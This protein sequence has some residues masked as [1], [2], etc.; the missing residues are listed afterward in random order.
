M[1]LGRDILKA[2]WLNIQWYDHVIEAYDGTL[3]GSMA[4]IVDMGT[5]GFKI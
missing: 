1:I 4:T 5:Y 3:K 2:L